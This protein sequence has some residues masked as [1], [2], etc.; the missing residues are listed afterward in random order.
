[1][2]AQHL[3]I[4]E[5]DRA[6]NVD[7]GWIQLRILY[8]WTSRVSCNNGLIHEKGNEAVRESCP[9]Q[10][11][12]RQGAGVRTSLEV[13]YNQSLRDGPAN[14][15]AASTSSA[16]PCPRASLRWVC[17]I[18]D[19]SN[20]H[21]VV[22]AALSLASCREGRRFPTKTGRNATDVHSSRG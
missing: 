13:K 4:D 7:S 11:E 1:M 17:F 14:I 10:S 22:V 12:E 19:G 6:V 2:A 21:I 15:R 9:I 18:L 8:A 20:T 5:Q 3:A 16:V